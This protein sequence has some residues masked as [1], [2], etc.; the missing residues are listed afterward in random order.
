[1]QIKK[2]RFI[3]YMV[4]AFLGGN[5]IMAGICAAVFGISTDYVRVDRREYEEMSEAYER[6]GKLEQLYDTVNQAF[7]KEI[8]EDK[9]ME[10]AYKGL[11]AGLEDPYSSYMTAKEYEKW[12]SSVTGEYSGIG[13]TFSL[14]DKGN[15]VIVTVEKGSPAEEGG[16]KAG[17]IILAVDGREYDD[18]DIMGN[19]IR[20]KDGSKVRITYVREGEKKEASLVREKIVQH[21]VEHEMLDKKT[22][23]IAISSFIEST[24][25]DFKK[26]LKDIEGKGA[27]CLVLDLRDNGGGLVDSCVAIADEFLDKGLVVYMEDR[28]KSKKEYKA[29]DGK[30]E[31]ETVVLVNENS[32][33]ASEILAAALKDNGIRLV[34]TT[35]YGKGVVQSTAAMDDGSALKL[36][37]MQYFSPKGNAINKVGVVPDYEIKNDENSETDM[38]LQKA[39]SLF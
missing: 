9:L 17:D 8:D 33:S 19:A 31:L 21:S 38:Q 6:Y 28:N 32:A 24:E 22:G 26:A 10:S 23:Y 25:D 30:T 14:D 16:L 36:T 37:I 20:G 7:Y 18:I 5:V 13:I 2:K 4:A 12:K 1:M 34:G 27:E 11:I 15:A 39:L 3:I 29:E 35:T